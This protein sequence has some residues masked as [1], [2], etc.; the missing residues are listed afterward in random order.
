[1]KYFL[2][3][4]L[5][6]GMQQISAQKYVLLD[7]RIYKP[8]TYANTI[9][10]ADKFN[11]F[12][13]VEKKNLKQFVKIL[14]EIEK[15]LS[16]GVHLGE[17][18]QYEIGCTKFSGLT[19]PSATGDRLDYVLTSNCDNV[20]ISMHLSDAKLSNHSN[21]FFIKTWIKYIKSFM[22]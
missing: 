4:I 20:V 15:K 5:F 8:V 13:P 1:M 21:A 7:K 12:F 14:D 22:K 9:T 16:G 17:A 10:S 2:L 6:T 18:M 19:F 3:F 11:G